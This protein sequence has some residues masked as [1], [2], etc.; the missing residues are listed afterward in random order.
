MRLVAEKI[1]FF[2][3]VLILFAENV[4]A[5]DVLCEYPDEKLTL[6]Y[7]DG[8]GMPAAEYKNWSDDDWTVNILLVKLGEIG[9]AHV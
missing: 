7:T 5:T 3:L 8:R 1:F 2:F 4:F 9:R 6:T